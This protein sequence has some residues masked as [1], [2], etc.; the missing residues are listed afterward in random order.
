[1]KAGRH[2]GL[3]EAEE[4][5]KAGKKAGSQEDKK[6]DKKAAR[7]TENSWAGRLIAKSGEG[8]IL[9]KVQHC[10]LKLLT[11]LNN[12][13]IANFIKTCIIFKH[14]YILWSAGIDILLKFD[15]VL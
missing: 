13:V 7:Q 15:Y 5:N 1:M 10:V 6:T 9:Q 8:E 14:T 2:M 11:S 4:D 12:Q 3:L